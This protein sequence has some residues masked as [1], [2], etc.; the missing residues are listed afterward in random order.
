MSRLAADNMNV[1]SDHP[2]SF[3]LS[4]R[5]LTHEL[6]GWA[7]SGLGCNRHRLRSQASAFGGS[8]RPEASK[9]ISRSGR[10]SGRKF[11]RPRQGA[12]NELTPR[13]VTVTVHQTGISWCC[14]LWLCA[15]LVRDSFNACI[16]F[17]ILAYHPLWLPNCD[18][19]YARFFA[20]S[21][22]RRRSHGGLHVEFVHASVRVA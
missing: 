20:Q 9:I 13:A 1:V 6:I 11:Q 15:T 21:F 17:C 2:D 18:S 3:V 16:D 14:S 10:I 19:C 7:W 12:P 8:G 22:A 4:R 5:R